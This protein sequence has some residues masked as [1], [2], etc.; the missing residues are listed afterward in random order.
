M[1]PQSGA[2]GHEGAKQNLQQIE[3]N[4]RNKSRAALAGQKLFDE[5]KRLYK[6][7]T[8]REQSNPVWPRH[9]RE[10]TGQLQ[11][12]YQYEFAEGLPESFVEA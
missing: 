10:T 12:G 3:A 7:G 2:H 1:V 5:C 6:A 11:I 4:A 8:R 9:R